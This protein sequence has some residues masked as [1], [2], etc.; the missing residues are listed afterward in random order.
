VPAFEGKR[1]LVSVRSHL[2]P[3]SLHARDHD[4]LAGSTSSSSSM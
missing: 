3:A 2:R 4:D 1:L